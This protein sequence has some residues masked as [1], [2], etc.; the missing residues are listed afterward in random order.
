MVRNLINGLICGGL[1]GLT[2]F[3]LI[4]VLIGQPIQP[5]VVTKAPR[6]GKVPI[7]GNSSTTIAVADA[8]L[9]VDSE[10]QW[11]CLNCQL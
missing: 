11:S 3:V 6:S 7:T 9:V 8:D 4:S 2:L 10:P 5:D 1:V